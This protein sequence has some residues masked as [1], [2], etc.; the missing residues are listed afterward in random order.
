MLCYATAAAVLGILGGS[1]GVGASFLL[2][3]LPL[4]VATWSL[5]AKGAA[6]GIVPSIGVILP[7]ILRGPAMLGMAG[8]L[9]L[10]GVAL[11]ALGGERVWRWRV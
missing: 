1:L 10:V 9:L 2:A 3:S 6:G 8:A 5:G 4:A 11:V 7:A